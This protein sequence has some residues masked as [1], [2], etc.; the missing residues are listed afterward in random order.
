MMF[1]ALSVWSNVKLQLF[2]GFGHICANE[3]HSMAMSS[4]KCADES[5][6]TWSDQVGKADFS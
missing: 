1:N 3:C 4:T 6:F 5:I 2:H